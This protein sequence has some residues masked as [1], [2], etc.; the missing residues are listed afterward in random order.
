MAQIPTND[1]RGGMKVEMDN[2]PYTVVGTE[3]VKPGKGQAFNRIKLKHL[4]SGR[5]IEKTFKSTEKV[6][7]ADVMEQKLRLLYQEQEGAV[8]MD[9]NSFEQVT[10]PFSVIKDNKQWL[11]DDLVYDLIFYKGV[12][13]DLIPPTFMELTITETAP[14]VRGDTASGRVM[15]PAILETGAK[16]QVPIFIEE[17]EKIKVDT[18][19]CEYVSRV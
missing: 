17:R 11:K 19:T 4:L 14:G 3:F 12:V 7:L 1:L 6:E 15:K 8:F 13:V 10:V 16:V 18:R 5:V 9:D 2:E